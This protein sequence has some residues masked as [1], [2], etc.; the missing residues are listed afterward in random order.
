MEGTLGKTKASRRQKSGAVH[1]A[2]AG[3]TCSHV[4][5]NVHK[6][7][8]HIH[9]CSQIQ[10]TY[11]QMFINT[12][13]MYTQMFMNTKYMYTQM[14]R[15]TKYI[16]ANVHKYQVHI[17]KYSEIPSTY[18]KNVHKY[19]VHIQLAIHKCSQILILIINAKVHKSQLPF[20]Y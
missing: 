9:K 7:Q 10:S 16:Y 1:V 4:H 8:L 12:K 3:H 20:K 19:Q 13:Y 14:F 2:R 11:T 5:T 6:Y 18:T 17:H 15:N